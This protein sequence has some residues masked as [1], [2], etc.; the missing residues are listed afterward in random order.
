MEGFRDEAKSFQ[1]EFG[2][3]FEK[4]H[5]DD[6]RTFE[7]ITSKQHVL[8]NST[9][10]LYRNNRYR[11]S[12]NTHAYF[13]LITFLE[14]QSK[15]GGRVILEILQT[16]FEIRNTDRGPTD[17][18]SFDQLVN[19][20]RTSTADDMAD[21]REGI[22]GAYVATDNLQDTMLNNKHVDLGLLPMDADLATDVRAELESLDMKNPP[23]SEQLSLLD[24]FEQKIKR[25]DSVAPDLAAQLPRPA[26]RARD[27]FMEVQ[28]VREYRNR[29]RIEGRTGGL[30]PAVSVCMWTF[31]NTQDSQ[32][33]I[34]F[35]FELG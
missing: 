3:Q 14:A 21:F 32:V 7:T 25:E 19:K 22:D 34:S 28:K 10:N 27:V 30:G 11:F 35:L 1:S 8:E 4:L 24:T 16:C 33:F 13:S 9:A 29:Y 15:K 20:G 18:Y 31:H 5:S 17:Q 23:K 2:S 26:T 6:L 12:L